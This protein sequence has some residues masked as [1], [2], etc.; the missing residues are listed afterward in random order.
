MNDEPTIRDV[1]DEVISL[2]HRL[3]GLEHLVESLE[4]LIESLER[5]IETPGSED[6]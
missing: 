6:K 2:R 4:R 5:L 1:L 3:E